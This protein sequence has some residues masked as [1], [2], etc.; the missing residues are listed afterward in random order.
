[1][2]ARTNE[3]QKCISAKKTANKMNENMI[4]STIKLYRQKSSPYKLAR[5]KP[6]KDVESS[7]S[8]FS[9]PLVAIN[10]EFTSLSQKFM[11]L[12]EMVH[13]MRE[14]LIKTQREVYRRKSNIYNTI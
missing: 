10:D 14:N 3:F 12:T 9:Q 2:D 6:L 7:N 8:T 5:N 4:K 1:M 11:N 13:N